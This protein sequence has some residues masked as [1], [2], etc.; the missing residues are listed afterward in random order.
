LG[1]LRWLGILVGTGMKEGLKEEVERNNSKPQSIPV[2]V[3]IINRYRN[4]RERQIYTTTD[5]VVAPKKG[6]DR[7][8]FEFRG[9]QYTKGRLVLAMI[10]S[11]AEEHYGNTNAS[12]LKNRLQGLLDKS[13]RKINALV[14]YDWAV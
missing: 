9:R 2:A 6:K 13:D 7:S 12:E 1:K 8:R 14:D 4:D 3:I 11:Y 5:I 10:K